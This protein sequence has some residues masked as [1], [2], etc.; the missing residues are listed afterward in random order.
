MTERM[1]RALDQAIID[2]WAGLS[3]ETVL[4]S[5]LVALRRET[6]RPEAGQKEES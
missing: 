5:L 1:D 4:I 6:R 3:A 2:L